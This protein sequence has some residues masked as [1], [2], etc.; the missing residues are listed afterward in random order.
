[1]PATSE[2]TPPT[3][4]AVAGGT[5][6][7]L[8]AANPTLQGSAMDDRQAICSLDDVRAQLPVPVGWA[9]LACNLKKAPTMS[10]PAGGF[11]A[12]VAP[13]NTVSSAMLPSEL[14]TQRL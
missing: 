6:E 10:R 9:T 14:R 2:A 7:A 3:A 11:G 4:R 13:G 5:S 8:R 12:L 1:M